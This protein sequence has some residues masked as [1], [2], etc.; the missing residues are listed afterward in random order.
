M[1]PVLD[2]ATTELVANKDNGVKIVQVMVDLGMRLRVGWSPECTTLRTV[3][4]ERAS[5]NDCFAIVCRF[6]V[7][8]ASWGG[9]TN[10]LFDCFFHPAYFGGP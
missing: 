4:V 7:Q 8:K 1:E 6:M 10:H 5:R 9:P 3:F 2:Q